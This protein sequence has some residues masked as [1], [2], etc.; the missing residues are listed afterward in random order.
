MIDFLYM[1]WGPGTGPCG[2]SYDSRAGSG[3]AGNFL[4]LQRGRGP[5]RARGVP[6]SKVPKPASTFHQIRSTSKKGL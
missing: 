2:D 6:R 4:D 5:S 3:A 1:F